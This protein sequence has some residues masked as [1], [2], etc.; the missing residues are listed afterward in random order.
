MTQF[1]FSSLFRLRNQLLS[2]ITPPHHGVI[3][4]P[5]AYVA[6]PPGQCG[7]ACA[8]MVIE[9]FTQQVIQVSELAKKYQSHRRYYLD[10]VGWTHHGLVD[11]MAKYDIHAQVFKWR[12]QHFVINQLLHRRLVIVSLSVPELDNASQSEP[13]E[14]INPHHPFTKH[15]CVAYGYEAGNILLHDP[16]GIGIY[17]KVRV[18]VKRFTEIFSGNGIVILNK[19]F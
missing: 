13:Y 10:K 18:P 19:I 4:L 5:L 7:L 12:S 17:T 11:L 3:E 9:V 16:R 8:A 2:W 14:A 1:S 15:L 6:A